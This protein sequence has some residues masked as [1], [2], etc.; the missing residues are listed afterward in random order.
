MLSSIESYSQAIYTLLDTAA[1]VRGHT[2]RIYPRGAS[3]GVMEGKSN[4]HCRFAPQASL[5]P[6]QQVSGVGYA[7]PNVARNVSA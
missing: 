4:K 2:I 6:S 1:T 7:E 3:V 5:S